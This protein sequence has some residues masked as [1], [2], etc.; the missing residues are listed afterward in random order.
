MEH[1]T[2]EP[3]APSHSEDP[4]AVDT[5]EHPV[6]LAAHH[7]HHRRHQR[8]VIG[9]VIAGLAVYEIGA[10]TVN[11]FFDEDVVPSISPWLIKPFWPKVGIEAR[12]VAWVAAS[13]GVLGGVAVGVVAVGGR[14]RR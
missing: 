2:Q 10:T 11:A 7:H 13:W 4:S 5:V 1:A 8:T 14:R 6:D 9:S 12:H 3:A